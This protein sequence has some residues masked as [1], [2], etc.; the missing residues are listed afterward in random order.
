MKN[1]FKSLYIFFVS[2]PETKRENKEL[3]KVNRS[4]NSISRDDPEFFGG[5][6]IIPFQQKIKE[7]SPEITS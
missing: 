4:L 1:L 3:R 5:E 6:A 2:F 7:K